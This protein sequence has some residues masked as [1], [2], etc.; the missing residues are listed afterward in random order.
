MG[1]KPEYNR[2]R[3]SNALKVTGIWANTIGVEQE[4]G[5]NTAIEDALY[6]P[7]FKGGSRAEK[8]Q[9]AQELMQAAGYQPA[10]TDYEGLKA[11]AK[12]AGGG[13][14]N[15]GACKVCG[16]LGHLTKRCRNT[17][18]AA[19]AAEGRAESLAAR[20]ALPLLTA[21]DDAEALN[22]LLSSGSGSDSDGSGGGKKRKRHSSGDK[23]KKHK[24]EHKKD[25]KSRKDKDK[26]KDKKHKRRRERSRSR[27]RSR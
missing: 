3:A 11:L 7:G 26:E 12:A 9:R 20:A 27:S 18:A 25:K 6:A 8:A 19:A 22:E 16:G 15:R 5:G 10:V 14:A 2:V 17:A 13:T 1:L 24:K 23:K 4:M 21:A